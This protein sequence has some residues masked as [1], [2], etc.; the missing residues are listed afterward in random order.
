MMMK[1]A[2]QSSNNSYVDNNSA[3]QDPLHVIFQNAVSLPSSPAQDHHHQHPNA[4]YDHRIVAPTTNNALNVM[5]QIG[6]IQGHS[7]QQQQQQQPHP[8]Q[9]QQPQVFKRKGKKER[10]R[11]KAK[12]AAAEAA[13]VGTSPRQTPA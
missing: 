9:P 12:L 1:G 6:M 11:M 8:Q 5:Q 7:Q 2:E 10:Q 3:V 4:V 13:G